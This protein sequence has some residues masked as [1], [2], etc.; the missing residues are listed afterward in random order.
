MSVLKTNPVPIQLPIGAEDTFRGIVDLVEM[1]ADVY[2]D[3]LG[4]DMRVEEIPDDMKEKAEQYR[5]QM[6]EAIAECDEELFELYCADEEIS[7][8]M[9]RKAIRKG[10]IENKIV[11]VVCGTSYKNKGVQKLLDA[12][13]DYMPSPLDVPHIKGINP[14]TEQ[15]EERPSS[16]DEP[17][18]ALAFKIMTDPYVGSFASYVYIRERSRQVLPFI[19]QT[20]TLRSVWADCCRCTPTTVRILRSL[21]RAIS[22]L[23]SVLRAPP[24][25]IPS[26]TR[27]I[28]S[29]SSL[30]SSRARYPRCYRA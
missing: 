15:E 20:R 29:S 6:I 5:K 4:K 7:T 11:P 28:L 30:W 26:A 8:D 14:E 16:D 13:V 23:P 12:I 1:N 19:M 27:S 21:I 2:Y 9:I 10:C 25:V 3:D 24:Q 18:A 17:F 22:V